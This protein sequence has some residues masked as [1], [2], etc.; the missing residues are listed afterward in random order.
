MPMD[1]FNPPGIVQKLARPVTTSLLGSSRDKSEHGNTKFFHQNHCIRWHSSLSHCAG[2]GRKLDA[3][4]GFYSSLLLRLLLLFTL[5]YC[6]N[7]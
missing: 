4:P 6:F 1:D 7:G 2:S 5:L 3:H